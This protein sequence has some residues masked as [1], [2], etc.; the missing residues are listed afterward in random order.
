MIRTFIYGSC[1]SRDTFEFVPP[2]QF[3]LT[4]YVARQSLISAMT[5]ARPQP[6]HPTPTLGAFQRRSLE[7]DWGSGLMP[8]LRS[9]LKR[10]ELLLWDLCDERL[11]VYEFDDGTFCTRSVDLIGS[12][13]E[14]TAAAGAQLHEFGTVEHFR[15]WTRSM[16]AFAAEMADCGLPIILIAPDWA[17]TALDGTATP[18]SFGLTATRAN[19]IYPAYYAAAA[20]AARDHGL[21]LDII[22]PRTYPDS[23]LDRPT[24]RSLTALV[25]RLS[26]RVTQA[27]PTGPI[28]D[29]SHKWG[30]APF[31]YAASVYEELSQSISSMADRLESG[32]PSS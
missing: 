7:S 28:A 15:L 30:L 27:P 6:L 22:P 29:P 31:H 5:P 23:K 20:D 32:D 13:V 18:T 1:V 19:E 12:G 2:D 11:G 24:R 10:V 14:D 25:R 16:A 9:Q 3:V 26:R 17:I 21:A 4:K 8:T